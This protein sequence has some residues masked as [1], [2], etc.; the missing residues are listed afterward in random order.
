MG[1][2]LCAQSSA[3]RAPIPYSAYDRNPP[4]PTLPRVVAPGKARP[5]KKSRLRSSLLWPMPGQQNVRAEH[6]RTCVGGEP[7]GQ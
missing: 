2:Q 7:F 5:T 3:N 6:M 1:E 4:P